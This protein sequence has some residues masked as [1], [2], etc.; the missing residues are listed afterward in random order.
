ME[1]EIQSEKLRKERE[2]LGFSP[3]EI[4]RTI[5]PILS[6]AG[7]TVYVGQESEW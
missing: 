7:V 5:G 6:A 4:A 3:R 1:E 2:D